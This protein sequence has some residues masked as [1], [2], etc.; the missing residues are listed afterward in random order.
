M[1]KQE[2]ANW[3]AAIEKLIT[4]TEQGELEWRTVVGFQPRG[5]DILVPP[6][7]E[8]DVRGRRLRVYEYEFKHYTDADE[9]NWQTGVAIEFVNERGGLEY[10]WPGGYFY[11]SR[12][13]AAIRF[14]AAHVGEFLQEFLH[15]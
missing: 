6:A 10:T 8:A 12:L 11:R 14:Q 5:E 4:M 7:F 1:A 13:I 9:Y 15:E 3:D 2:S